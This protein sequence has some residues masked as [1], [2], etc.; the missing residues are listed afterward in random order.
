LIDFELIQEE[1]AVKPRPRR[2]P[3][4]PSPVPAPHALVG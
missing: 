4:A 3:K 2:K 1:T